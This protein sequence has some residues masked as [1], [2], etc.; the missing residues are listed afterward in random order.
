M[1]VVFGAAWRKVAGR[2]SFYQRNSFKTYKTKPIGAIQKWYPS[3]PLS[4]IIRGMA[5]QKKINPNDNNHIDKKICEI[6]DFDTGERPIDFMPLAKK[7]LGIYPKFEKA[8][9]DEVT[10]RKNNEELW[11]L[12]T[13]ERTYYTIS[14]DQS[15]KPYLLV[16]ITSR[17]SIFPLSHGSFKL[18]KGWESV[19]L[20]FYL[21]KRCI[22]GMS[23]RNKAP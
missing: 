15:C 9:Q 5:P 12:E 23:L 14:L 2:H 4:L 8:F 6:Y 7:S 21:W 18:R 19:V 10:R 22:S 20:N 11:A 3:E 13:E 17:I 16:G 1:T